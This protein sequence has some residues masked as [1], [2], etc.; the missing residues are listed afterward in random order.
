M[1]TAID[2]GTTHVHL[3]GPYYLRIA[4]YKQGGLLLT[5]ATRIKMDGPF[6]ETMPFSDYSRV[7]REIPCR[8]ATD[9]AIKAAHETAL[10]M[11]DWVKAECAAHYARRAN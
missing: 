10:E 11:L 5:R 9:K 7:I 8:R 1:I 2:N 4:T 3:D 6:W